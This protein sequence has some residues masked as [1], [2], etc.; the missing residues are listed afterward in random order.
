M[1]QPIIEIRNLTFQ[2][3]AADAP[4][5]RDVSL[6]VEAGETV[7]LLGPSGCGKSTLLLCLNGIIPHRI[8]GDFS[9]QVRVAG[10][11][12]AEHEVHEM[13]EKVGLVFQDP[14]A[15]FSMLYVEDEVAFGLEN[16]RYPRAVIR[17]RIEWA[18]QMVGLAHK[19]G[20]RLDHLSGGEKQKVALASVLAMEPEVLVFDAPTANLDP[21]SARDFFALLRRLK[22]ELGK[23]LVIVEQR[24]DDLIAMV[25]RLV[26]LNARGEVIGNGPPREVVEAVGS[27]FL[28]RYGIW[29]PQAWELV[30]FARQHGAAIPTYPFTTEEAYTCLVPFL[31]HHLPAEFSQ[32][33]WENRAA[34]AM[35]E[36]IT[37]QGLSHTYPAYPTGIPALRDVRFHVQAGDFCAIVGQNGAGKTTLAKYITRILEPPPGTVFLNGEDVAGLPLHEVTRQIG[38]VFQNPE[39][40]FV[41]DTVYDELAYSLRV[42]GVE[43]RVVRERVLEM[44]ETFQLRSLAHRHPFELSQGEKRRLSVATMLIVEPE[45]LILDEPTLGLDKAT[46]SI[47]MEAMRALNEQG[48]TI[49]FITHDM[50]LVAEYARSVAVMVAGEVIF[51]GAVRELFEH[52]DVMAASALLVPPMVALSRRFREVDPAF[53]LLTSVREFRQLLEVTLDAVPTR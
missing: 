11:D 24:V 7:L 20:Q 33:G 3:E 53:P 39:H 15:Q 27:E 44:L 32:K 1:T 25:D 31:D 6:S 50:R 38:Y 10:L 9:G 19:L 40:Q 12:V 36:I 28:D 47:L 21:A 37:V 29:I 43:E 13:A 51:Q 34:A 18:L 49:L 42:R 2:Y 17:Q 48:R 8:L 26:L 30:D 35:P 45:V 16:L 5:L 23:T 41:E 4:V 14:E 22:E 46:A 52:A